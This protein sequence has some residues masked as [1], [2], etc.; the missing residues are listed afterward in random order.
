MIALIKKS[1]TK[2]VKLCSYIVD[3]YQRDKIINGFYLEDCSTGNYLLDAIHDE[4]GVFLF[5]H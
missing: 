5:R 3:E 1:K 2:E 4:G